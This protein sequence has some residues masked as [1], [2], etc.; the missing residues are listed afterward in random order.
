M[1]SQRP[2]RFG[3]NMLAPSSRDEWVG[4]ARRAEEL[5]YD[6]IG[7]A[8]HLGLP[9]PFPSLVL[10]AEATE[11]VR[12]NTFVLNTAFYNPLLLARDLTTTDR[13]TDGRL[14]IGLGAGY[15][16]A[17]FDAAEMPFPAARARVDHLEHTVEVLT[18]AF[19]DPDF[20]PSPLQQPGPPLLLAGRGDRVLA[21]AARHAD[22]IGFTGAA[23]GKDGGSPTLGSG[24]DVDERVRYVRT[25]L[26]GRTDSV[27]LNVLIQ[28]VAG[29]ADRAALVDEITPFV[30]A[31]AAAAVDDIPTVLVGSPTVMAER[32]RERRDRFGFSYVTVLEDAMESFAP[33]IG[34]L[35]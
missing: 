3:V 20:Q 31:E 4:R 26:A 32:L 24:N 6:V 28:K 11:R 35:K 12:L 10:A 14:E 17:E 21:L 16:K 30:T 23:A 7:V 22:V 9:A 8:D 2:F 29:E 33:V 25:L 19:A 1:P 13:F 18:K 34:L 27:E 15:V 5:G